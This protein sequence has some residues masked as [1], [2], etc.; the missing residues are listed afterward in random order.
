MTASSRRAVLTGLGLVTPLG[1]D[2]EAFWGALRGGRSGVRPIGSF[3]ASALPVRFGGEV[4][5]FDARSYLDKKDRKRLAVMSRSAQLAVAAARLA[6]ADAGLDPGRLDPGRFG[7]VLGA[8]TIPGD[9]AG[10][11]PA[12]RASADGRPGPVDPAAW[13]ERGLPC[14]PPMWMLTYVPNM[15]ACHVSILHNAQGPLNTITQ[16]DAA[17]LLALGEAYRAVRRGRADLFLAG[18]AD[19]R[20]T[21]INAA[22]HCLFG[23]LSRRNDAPERACR[24][25]DRRR[26]GEV[27]GEG[28]CVFV[29][30]EL[31][32]ARLRGAR[33]LAEVAGFGA[34]FDG[35]RSGRGLARAA[36]AALAEAG[37]SPEAVDHV[38]AR[39]ASTVDDDAWE[40]RGLQEV[41]GGRSPP[42]PVFA[43]KSYFGN[44]GAGSGAAELAASALALGHGLLPAT[45]NYEEPDPACPVAVAAVARP[46]C[47]PYVLKVSATELGQCAALVLRKS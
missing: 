7:V 12:A 1:L 8:A 17:S 23:R 34:A 27:L 46:V 18:G 30:E 36:R 13:A 31:G 10:L 44:L 24:P 39:G 14:I 21:P 28:G 29:L 37:V 11:G 15:P 47:R 41:F 20:V 40:A 16:G 3:D 22:R 32:H 35:D 26:D 43:A 45:L 19:T 4:V 33:I 38:N 25:F 6:A 5:G 9:M 42:V 2:A